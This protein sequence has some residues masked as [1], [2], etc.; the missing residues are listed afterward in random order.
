MKTLK[1]AARH[2]A[3]AK[4]YT[5]INVVGLALSLGCCIMLTRYLHREYTVDTHCID[6]EHIVVPLRDVAGNVSPTLINS[7]WVNPDTVYISD[8]Q[9]LERCRF[10]L[11]QNDNVLQGDRSFQA[12]V[13]VTDSVFFRLF[14]YP[15][16]A[17]K[18]ALET[19]TDVVLTEDCARRLFGRENPVGQVLSYCGETATVRGVIGQPVCKTTF[20]FD[21]VV[22]GGLSEH[23]S[24]MPAELIHVLPSVDLQAINRHARVYREE[25]L[26]EGAIGMQGNKSV[27]YHFLTLR[28]FYFD[29]TSADEENVLMRRQGNQRALYL[30]MGVVVLLLLVGMLNFINI[31][32]VLM[33]KRSKE[34]G[35]KKVFGLQRLP[36]FL[37]IYAENFLLCAG[38]LILAWAL[39]EIG[40]PVLNRQVGETIGYTTFDTWLSVVFLFLFPLLTSAYPYLRYNYRPPMLSLRTIGTARQ[41]VAVRMVFLFMQYLVTLLLVVL[42]VYFV[43]QL[44]LWMDM[45]PGFRTEGI[46]YADLSRERRNH[47]SL[48]EV[49]ERA[50]YA[51]QQEVS[52][53]I[54]ACPYIDK[55]LVISDADVLSQGYISTL[56]NDRGKEVA[57]TVFFVPAGFF[58]FYDIPVLE[59]SVE[60]QGSDFQM[61]LNRR[62]M[63]LFGYTSR[64][65]AFVRSET[66]LWMSYSAF[67][68]EEGGTQLMPVSAVVEN[69][70]AGHLSCGVQPMAFLMGGP[71]YGNKWALSVVPGRERDLMN[72]LRETAQEAYHTDEFSFTHLSDLVAGIYA[73][74]RRV[75]YICTAFALIAILVSCLG[76][77]GVSLFDIRQRY[78]EIAIRKVNGAKH[79]DLYRLL[80]R[81][82]AI[83][84]GT[85]F[86]GSV[87]LG[88]YIVYRYTA[89]YV[90]K[91]PLQIWIFVVALLLVVLLSWSMLWWQIRQAASANP[92]DSLKRE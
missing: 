19:P 49:E 4:S 14:R 39:V 74:D 53:R 22:A 31:Y 35:I 78:R 83:V 61:V 85:A 32:M 60:W 58:E 28:E 62:A 5:I 79:R 57:V 8:S 16:R 76:L 81:K 41:S 40:Q 9:V 73:D 54:E 50:E 25:K 77:L 75:A 48:G 33:M 67:G 80:F 3:R 47:R 15:V 51:R 38:A 44:R 2:L 64:E 65:E 87:P 89:D 84:L 21:M 69:Y 36:L 20:D 91:A 70:C 12:N 13:L 59:G 71:D 68:I 34:Y 86:V 24:R 29:Q 30:F 11:N 45:P 90:V 1:Y 66:P 27:R 46:V 55:K 18:A 92:V 88:W 10:I 43:Q 72:Y 63:E 26:P 23:W 52:H 56:H 37:Q 42:S 7:S 17:G 6:R 82:Y